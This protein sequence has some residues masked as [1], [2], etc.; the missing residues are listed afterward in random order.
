MHVDARTLDAG[1]LIEGDLCIIGAGAAGISLALEWI[2]SKQ[3]VILLEGGG[4]ALEERMQELYKGQVLDQPYYPLHSTRLHY[5]GGTTGHWAGWCSPFDPLDFEKRAWVPDS[6]WPFAKATLD[7]FYRRAQQVLEL[8]EHPF[9]PEYWEKRDPD[10]DRMPLSRDTFVPKMWEFSPPTR[11]GTVYREAIVTAANIHLHTYAN[12]VEIMPN[13]NVTAVEGLRVKAIGGNEFRVKA[14]HYVT[15]CNAIHNA[16]LLLASNSRARAGLGNDH[17]LVGRFF[18]EHFEVF[19]AQVVFEAPQALKLYMHPGWGAGRARAEIAL[20][21][22]TQ[23]RHKVLNGTSSLTVFNAATPRAGEST[24]P[25]PAVSPDVPDQTVYRLFTRQEQSPN[26]DSRVVLGTET[27]ELGMPRANLKLNYTAL[28]KHSIRTFY[29]LL[30]QDMGKSGLG[31]LHILEWLRD[32]DDQAWPAFLRHG[33]HHMGTARMHADPKQG[34]VDVNQKVHGL[35]NLY[36]A[37]SDVYPT[38]SAV[39]PT[40]TLVALTL[41]LSDHLKRVVV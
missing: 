23:R 28:D 29:E 13:E 32:R 25:F 26:R 7:P 8:G 4:F 11:M 16:R 37:G 24:V 20:T 39:N 1:T 9:E 21:A 6:G 18:Q 12:V 22:D 3:K 30:A 41:R 36:V 34:V 2:G 17:D 10:R 5:F 40:L 33:W 31:R 27:D 35:A 15:A 14:R 38:S 19:G